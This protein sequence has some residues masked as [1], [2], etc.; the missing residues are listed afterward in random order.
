M[1]QKGLVYNIKS[2][3]AGMPAIF[4]VSLKFH[5]ANSEGTF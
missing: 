1:L 3:D 2:I 4:H 5:Q